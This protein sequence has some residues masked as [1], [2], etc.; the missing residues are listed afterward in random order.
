[1]KRKNILFITTDQ[2]MADAIGSMGNYYTPNLEK[3]AKK[4]IKFTK[5]I[6]TSAQ[7]SPSR[8]TWMTGRYPHEVGVNIIGHMLDPKDE[9]IAM[10][11]NRGG[12]NTV[13]LGKWHLGGQPSNYGFQITDYRT[14]GIDLSGANEHPAF[15]SHRDAKT[16]A[17]ALN[18]LDDC[19]NNEPFFM[20]VS[21]FMPHPNQP[22]FAKKEPFEDVVAF[23]DIYKV[24]EMP[25][26]K[27]F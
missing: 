19:T 18:Y 15:F 2:Q 12:Y 4:G 24:D 22:K 25:V 20:H 10:A 17:Q 26:P 16:T 9:N 6:V 5:H 27:S 11:F 3:L 13:Y 14:D 23:D 7:C 1:M 21:W 8:A